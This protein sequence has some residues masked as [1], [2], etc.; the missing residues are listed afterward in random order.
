MQ[1][2]FTENVLSLIEELSGFVAS[3]DEDNAEAAVHIRECAER[4]AGLQ[5]ARDE[6]VAVAESVSDIAGK[7][8]DGETPF[9]E[10]YSAL[11]EATELLQRLS[12]ETNTEE[13]E[14]ES[15]GA[16]KPVADAGVAAVCLK[17]ADISDDLEM[18]LELLEGL[19][20]QMNN[21]DGHILGVIKDFFWKIEM[22]VSA[23]ADAVSVARCAAQIAADILSE[24]TS[25]EIGVRELRE[26]A[27]WFRRML[28]QVT[29]SAGE[30]P[31]EGFESGA[32]MAIGEFL[33]SL[34]EELEAFETG[35]DDLAFGIADSAQS[36]LE[37]ACLLREAAED[38]G[39]PDVARLF[40]AV[41]RLLAGCGGRVSDDMTDALKDA[42]EYVNDC[43]S[44]SWHD[45]EKKKAEVLE[46]VVTSLEYVGRELASRALSSASIA[47]ASMAITFPS[48]EIDINNPELVDFITESREYLHTSEVALVE[49]EKN[50]G[51]SALINEIF[52]GFHNIKGIAGFLNL[53]DVQ[54]VA[55]HAESLL[56]KARRG[57]IEMVGPTANASF[58]AVDFMKEMVEGINAAMSGEKYATPGGYYE[59]IERLKNP[60]ARESERNGTKTNCLEGVIVLGA[61]IEES[62][63]QGTVG[64]E[65]RAG[66]A[67]ADGMVKVST[68]RLD[69][70]IDAVGELVIAN[71]MVTQEKEIAATKNPKLMRNVSHL[72]KITRELQE[73]AMSMRM[74]SL[75]NT[76]QKMTRLA[77]DLSVKCGTAVEL[78]FSGEDT[79]LD[80]NV[81]EEISSPL[82]HM[83]RNSVDHG[84]ETVEERRAA[85]KPDKGSIHLSAAHEGGTVVIRITDDGRGLNKEAI[86][87]KAIAQ[88][89][90][91]ADAEMSD[92]DIFGLI[93]HAGFSTA[94]KVTEVS[95][96]GVG[97]D[98][99]KRS[100]EGLRGRI[101]IESE[102]G[103]GSVFTIRLPL[104]LAIID[105]MVV[106]VANEKYI[107]PTIA[108]VE[109][110]RP[111]ASQIDTVVGKGEML[112]VRGD[113][114]PLFRVHR[115]F[116][117]RNAKTDPTNALAVVIGGNGS[118]CAL[119]VDELEG[120][121]QVVIKTLGKTFDNLDGVSGG[122][123]MGDGR[124]ALILDTT[125]MIRLAHNN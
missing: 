81:V 69:A 22:M 2:E 91:A 105:G 120:Q 12:R 29:E 94:K 84:I 107:I 20:D 31:G 89:I 23:S 5:G 16:E 40:E 33:E 65:S 54:E 3:M 21:K 76:F 50:P 113:L 66:N 45:D 53:K 118:R 123:I 100:I 101:E 7:L 96:R 95:G 60:V 26:S 67:K 124:V 49:L 111:S 24:E 121:Q 62:A 32:N 72:G 70:L 17:C 68:A 82:V 83:V 59:L 102:T 78:T 8:L 9:G 125:G 98:V 106:N 116:D 97:M 73:L 86:L 80:R 44:G 71:A 30:T 4:I 79:E 38:A 58:A 14:S 114:M 88:N 19:L 39:I 99:V 64:Q 87:A 27:E 108:I 37:H 55:H 47:A 51:D 77:R 92:R 74:V 85:G 63:A 61:A 56:D 52:R 104:T 43:L 48:V 11:C 109:S 15:A 115:L 18:Q 117:L 110:L 119:M 13:P 10:G 6:M 34:A 42:K 1:D 93:F 122:A 103:K 28:S 36:V 46:R 41:E 57:D 90:V 35:I 75:K 25:F 112:S